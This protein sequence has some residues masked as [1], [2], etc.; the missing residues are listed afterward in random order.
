MNPTE[1]AWWLRSDIDL[2]RRNIKIQ[3]SLVTVNGGHNG[4]T[5]KTKAGRRPVIVNDKLV[6]VLRKHKARQ[7]KER[8]C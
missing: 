5:P 3:G 1:A 2:G 4:P 8:V 6:S 7:T